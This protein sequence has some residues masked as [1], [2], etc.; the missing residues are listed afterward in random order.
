MLDILIEKEDYE[1]ALRII[2]SKKDEE[3]LYYKIVCLIGMDKKKEALEV[4]KEAINKSEKR[5]YDILSLE[6]SLLMELGY[7]DE[8]YKILDTEL[9]MP[10]IPSQYEEL[11]TSTYEVLKRKKEGLNKSRSIY[12]M[13]TNEELKELLDPT[14]PPE[15]IMTAI[16]QLDNRNVRHFL[17]EIRAFLESDGP[18]YLKTALLEVLINQGLDVEIDINHDGLKITTN[19]T[20]LSRLMDLPYVEAISTYI[21][22]FNDDKDITIEKDCYDLLLHYLADIYPLEVDRDEYIYI[23][24]AIYYAARSNYQDDFG[25]ATFA[26]KVGLKPTIIQKYYEQIGNLPWLV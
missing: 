12:D 25:L 22:E 4:A 11:Y 21:Q 16:Y 20:T 10:Y 1:E 17:P 23:A 5:Y 3:S 26:N 2:G 6:I 13:L 24:A 19:P 9:S 14:K 18:N 7:D 15:I 8:A